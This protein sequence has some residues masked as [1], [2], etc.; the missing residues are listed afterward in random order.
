M[1]I[2]KDAICEDGAID[3]DI[4]LMTKG[5]CVGVVLRYAN[6]LDYYLIEFCEKFTKVKYKS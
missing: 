4:F 3:V 2:S 6:E 1:L 5:G